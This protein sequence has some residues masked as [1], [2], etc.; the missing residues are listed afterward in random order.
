MVVR[1]GSL[2][3][4]KEFKTLSWKDF[5]KSEYFKD[6]KQKVLKYINAGEEFRVPIERV[7]K[8]GKFPSIA[9][10][11]EVLR[12]DKEIVRVKLSIK[13]EEF[14]QI[15]DALGIRKLAGASALDFV[16][17]KDGDKL[18]YGID[19]SKA[20]A[21]HHYVDKGQYYDLVSSDVE[22]AQEPDFDF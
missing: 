18:S 3:S 19:K 12:N 21:N 2:G 20:F 4:D 15:L 16:I 9:I 8:G 13:K 7:L 14:R 22:D 6:F 5:K 10:I 1:L 17:F 11:W